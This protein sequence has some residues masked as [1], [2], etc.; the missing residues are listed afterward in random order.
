MLHHAVGGEQHAAARAHGREG[1][2]ALADAVAEQVRRRAQAAPLQLAASAR[3]RVSCPLP[4]EGDALIDQNG[5][6]YV[7]VSPYEQLA[8]VVGYQLLCD[9][10]VAQP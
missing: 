3:S 2:G 1:G 6:R 7:V 8:G 4:R 10:K 5:T 9:R